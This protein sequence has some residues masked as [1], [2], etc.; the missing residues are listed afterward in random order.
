MQKLIKEDL[1]DDDYDRL[2]TKAHFWLV[3]AEVCSLVFL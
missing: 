1:R 3:I 2:L